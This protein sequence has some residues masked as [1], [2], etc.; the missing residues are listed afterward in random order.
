MSTFNLPQRVVVQPRRS[1]ASFEMMV[2]LRESA[3]DTLEITRHPVQDGSSITDHAFV[4][5]KQ[6]EMEVVFANTAARTLK[7]S[8]QK[9]IEL[10][11][12]AVPFDVV[13]G[14]R[15]YK[16]MLIASL[17]NTTDA[18]N[19]NILSLSISMQEIRIV[20]VEVA[21]VP[22][23][24][25]QAQPAK[26]SSTQNSGAKSAQEEL[27]PQRRQSILSSIAGGF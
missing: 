20:Q 15:S 27:K 6:L 16:N 12:S 3:T 19:E 17:S 10:Q 26:T 18:D 11:A 1:I 25:R 4:Q 8:Y 13:T 2:V 21:V 14:K 24:S 7:E 5:P 23:R 22:P 9:F